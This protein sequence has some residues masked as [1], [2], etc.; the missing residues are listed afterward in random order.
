M[1]K[2][3]ICIV[4]TEKSERCNCK[5]IY[6][7]SL[8]KAL[9]TFYIVRMYNAWEE[10]YSIL[11]TEPWNLVILIDSLSFQLTSKLLKKYLKYNLVFV[12][13]KDNIDGY[14]AP[15]K[16][17]VSVINLSGS[18]LSVYGIPNEM[19]LHLPLP[20]EK[21]KDYYF[22]DAKPEVCRIVYCPTGNN[23]QEN[24]FNLLN[25]L[26]QTN[27]LLTIVSDRYEA[28]KDALPI[29][30]KVVPP[31]SLIAT[32]QKAHLVIA[33]GENA[34]QAMAFSKPCIILGDYGL[35]GLVTTDNYDQLQSIYFNGRKGGYFREMVPI[36]LLKIEIEKVFI[37]NYKEIT[38]IIQ[39]KVLAVYGWNS[40][41]K[42]LSYEI[43]RILNITE[44]IR[45]RKKRLYLKPIRTSLFKLENLDDKLYFYR[46]MVCFGEIGEDMHRL[47]ELCDGTNS[48]Q[49][50]VELYE[51]NPKNGEIIWKNL[52]QLWKEKLILFV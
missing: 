14:I 22:F 52:F 30:A 20:V 9:S 21:V 19:Q 17:L 36:N 16:N 7:E 51:Y 1:S 12:S 41:V 15:V 13:T 34:I 32:L 49:D 18:S 37:S 35:G 45:H 3:N 50:L 40:F 28:I 46:G 10:D 24:D 4:Y 29:F 6:I 11:E 42:K 43:E 8:Q 47:L 27:T 44:A 48:I 25:F 33:C 39:K 2:K 31:Q 26:S 5:N 38:K 23:I